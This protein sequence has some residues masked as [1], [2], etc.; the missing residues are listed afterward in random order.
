MNK[1]IIK[2]E[3]INLYVS[4]K[5]MAEIATLL[6]CSIHKIDYWMDKYS[7]KRR[8]RSEATYIKRNPDGDPFK[9][10]TKLSKDDKFLLGLG[11]GIYWGEGT[12]V[13]KHSLRVAN[14]DPG[15]IKMFVKFLTEIC[16]LRLNKITYSI[17]CFNDSDPNI[18][19]KFWSQE[20]KISPDRFGKI[21]QIPKQG[22][23]TYKKKSLYGVCT[24]QASNIKL[25]NWLISQIESTKNLA[26]PD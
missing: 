16:Q 23:G 22:K 18:A 14:S 7:V 1:K 20:L 13:T 11:I 6:N 3:L 12:K 4:G 21:T 25:R 2:K 24:V 15:I 26:V 10:K 17:I 9:I 5:S 8:N 19:R